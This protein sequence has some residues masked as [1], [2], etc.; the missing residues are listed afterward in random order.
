MASET[1]AAIIEQASALGVGVG[2]ILFLVDPE[3]Q[4]LDASYFELLRQELVAIEN[5]TNLR[6][7]NH[8]REFGSVIGIENSVGEPMF[9]PHVYYI[10]INFDLHIPFKIQER[11]GAVCDVEHFQVN[12]HSS[13]YMPVMYVYKKMGSSDQS[14]PSTSVVLVRKYLAEK[15]EDS[16]I[17]LHCIG[18]SPFHANFVCSNADKAPGLTDISIDSGY[19]FYIYKCEGNDFSLESFKNKYGDTFSLFYKLCDARSRGMTYEFRALE[20]ATN[21]LGF[22]KERGIFSALKRAWKSKSTIDDINTNMFS[23]QL[24]RSDIRSNLE[25]ARESEP[26][27]TFIDLSYHFKELQRFSRDDPYKSLTEI[28]KTYEARRQ[29]NLQNFAVLVSGLAGGVLGAILGSA[30]TFALTGHS[31]SN[32]GNPTSHVLGIEAKKASR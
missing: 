32:Q 8:D 29:S 18:P 10:D 6:I 23:D 12:I 19:K 5:L 27:Q 17:T 1:N 24:C 25:E 3:E 21:L 13:Y 9:F 16:P 31:Q 4:P 14:L 20:Q 30:L 11:I 26:T 7:V 2:C 28:V 22:D 15:L